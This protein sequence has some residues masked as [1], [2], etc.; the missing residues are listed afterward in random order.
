M[1][2]LGSVRLGLLALLAELLCR[3][4]QLLAYY[5][6]Y[7]RAV[8]ISEDNEPCSTLS[9]TRLCRL[10]FC[11]YGTRNTIDPFWDNLKLKHDVLCWPLNTARHGTIITL[12]L[13]KTI[14]YPIPKSYVLERSE[15]ISDWT[16]VNVI[17]SYRLTNRNFNILYLLLS[18]QS[19]E[20]V[21]F[22][23]TSSALLFETLQR[24]ITTVM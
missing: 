23:T 2:G 10:V 16:K 3:L 19:F 4:C 20:I 6:R 17:W 7:S 1:F 8:F 15:P 24:I 14:P 18:L 21:N 12:R 13:S 5:I 22:L 9:G 11:I